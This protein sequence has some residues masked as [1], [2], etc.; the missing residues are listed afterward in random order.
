MNKNINEP[1]KHKLSP[2]YSTLHAVVKVMIS[3][4][5]CPDAPVPISSFKKLSTFT[6]IS[7]IWVF[8]FHLYY[9]EISLKHP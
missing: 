3:Y 9:H 8:P 1:T 2:N 7:R 4:F 5:E 6:Q